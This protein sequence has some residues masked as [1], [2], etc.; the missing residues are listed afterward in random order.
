MFIVFDL[1]GTLADER[2]R[3]Y[4]VQQEPRN[5]HDYHDGAG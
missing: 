2:H 3:N 5:Y 4:L 1:D